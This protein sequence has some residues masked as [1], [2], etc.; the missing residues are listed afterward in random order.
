CVP[1][2]HGG[3]DACGESCVDLRTD[4][5]NCGQCF[6]SCAAGQRC[7]DGSCTPC[8]EGLTLCDGVC[9]DLTSDADHCGA[10]GARCA[11]A[12][13]DSSCRLPCPAPMLDCGGSCLDPRFD[14]A[15]CGDCGMACPSG[16]ACSDGQCADPAHGC[17]WPS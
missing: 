14:P 13:V 4:T 1:L 6:V 2:C 7:H 5:S 16:F 12:C 10:C 15:N 17:Q 11:G 8:P 3:E 9:T